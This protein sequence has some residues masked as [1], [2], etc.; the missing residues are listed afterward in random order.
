MKTLIVTL[1]IFFGCSVSAQ[2]A[3]FTCKLTFDY[4]PSEHI[5]EDFSLKISG[6]LNARYLLMDNAETFSVS[7]LNADT[8]SIHI[9]DFGCTDTVIHN[10]LLKPG[11]ETV[12]NVHI[13][14]RCVYDKSENDNTCPVCGKKDEVIPVEYGLPIFKNARTQRK[15]EKNPTFYAAGCEITCCD[16]NW[17]C[18][19]DKKLF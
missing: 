11:E 8:I 7:G 15:F 17:Y 6:G 16:P 4:P 2:T 14:S 9:S 13:P 19:R 10:I 18:K 12:L 1:F 3:S 5:L